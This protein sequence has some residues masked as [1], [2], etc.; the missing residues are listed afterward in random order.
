MDGFFGRGVLSPRPI[1][2]IACANK[3]VEE[4]LNGPL[5]QVQPRLPRHPPDR[6]EPPVHEPQQVPDELKQVR[7][8][9]QEEFRPPVREPPRV[10]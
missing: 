5:V 6:D 1:G 7:P 10:D 4:Q 9:V 2:E 8:Q 3:R